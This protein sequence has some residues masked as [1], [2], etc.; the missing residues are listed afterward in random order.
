MLGMKA[1]SFFSLSLLSAVMPITGKPSVS[2]ATGSRSSAL[3]SQDSIVFRRK[4]MA[5]ARANG[6][7]IQ[8]RDRFGRSRV[9]GAPLRAALRPGHGKQGVTKIL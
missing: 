7:R 9:C 5:L 3:S 6:S 4:A 2:F 1:P 8:D